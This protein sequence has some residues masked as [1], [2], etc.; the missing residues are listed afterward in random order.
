MP[1]RYGGTMRKQWRYVAAFAE[2]F[3]V[4][5]ARI[6]V[7]PIGQTFWAIVDRERGELHENTRTRLPG[8]RGEVFRQ[9]PGGGPAPN[10][11]RPHD[12]GLV[13]HI[14]T[15][16]VWA[17]LRVGEGT[18][19]ESVCPT[20]DGAYVWTRKRCDVPIHC[21]IRV[22]DRD[23]KIEARGVEDES[24]GYHP[25]HTVWS[26]SAGVGRAVDGRSVGWNLVSGINDP[27]QRS[28]RAIWLDGV[29]SEPGPVTF[30]DLDAIEFDDGSRLDFHGEA[31][32]QASSSMPMLSYEYRQPFGTFTGTLPGGVE[33]ESGLGVVEFHDAHW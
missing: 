28:E 25:H 18:W 1:L 4:C 9:R 33:L 3:H 31:E 11:G 13:D 24:A 15:E 8:A 16:H 26:W 21:H 27:P 29:P 20:A 14:Q 32:R 5:A 30:D 6:Q 17:R 7:G 22:G 23:W 2:P 12:A 10:L 19:A